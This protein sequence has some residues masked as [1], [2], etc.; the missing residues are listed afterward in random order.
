[1]KLPIDFLLSLVSILLTTQ[2]T[3]SN[4]VVSI[5][6]IKGHNR[7]SNHLLRRARV[8]LMVFQFA[9]KIIHL[10]AE[11]IRKKKYTLN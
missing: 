1:M 11:K 4:T 8:G 9:F 10:L 6:S 3:F 5:A 2:P 7:R